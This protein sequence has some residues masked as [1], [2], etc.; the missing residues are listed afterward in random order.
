VG[1]TARQSELGFADLDLVASRLG[2]D[3]I[4]EL[5]RAAGLLQPHF[6]VAKTS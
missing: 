2:T 5:G 1:L 3:R 6:K 4:M